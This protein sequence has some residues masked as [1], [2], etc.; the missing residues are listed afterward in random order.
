[1]R[2]RDRLRLREEGKED[3]I[4][5]VECNFTTEKACNKNSKHEEK[6]PDEDICSQQMHYAVPGKT[7]QLMHIAQRYL[8]VGT[9][10]TIIPQQKNPIYY[11]N[12]FRQTITL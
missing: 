12:G 1:M 7:T 11:L 2:L 9:H 10:E 4:V 6:H 5:I 3:I 8:L